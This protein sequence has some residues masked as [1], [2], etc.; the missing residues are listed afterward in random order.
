YEE[1][2]VINSWE[3]VV[4]TMIAQ[5][6]TKVFINNKTL[7]LTLASAPLKNELRYH[8]LVLIEKV[9]SYANKELIVDIKFFS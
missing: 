9:N 8:K 7:Y 4:G 2:A 3:K 1:A 5:K 6:T